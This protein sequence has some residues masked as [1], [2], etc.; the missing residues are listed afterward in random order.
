MHPGRPVDAVLEALRAWASE[1]GAGLGQVVVPGQDRSVAEPAP[2]EAFDLLLAIGGDGTTLAALRAGARAGRPVLGVACGSL[3]VLTSVTAPRLGWALDRFL[4]GEWTPRRLPA[5][6]VSAEGEAGEVVALN[7]LAVIRD[8]TGQ[9]VTSLSVD[10]V[11]YARMA[12]DGL[13]IATALGASAYSMAAGGPLLAP[14]AAGTVVT[15]LAPHGGSCPPLLAGPASRLALTVEPGYGG[16][17]FELDGQP[18]PLPDRRLTVSQR[19]DHVSLVV[20]EGE[21]PL[22]AGLRRRG[23]VLD[24]PRLLARDARAEL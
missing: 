10:G 15:P 17:R 9:L 16:V 18:A 22:F 7:D 24:S 5:L 1:H 3:G 14:G 2:A 23:L 13:I 20:L 6:V 21:E 4:A 12:G 8:G 19:P 11:L